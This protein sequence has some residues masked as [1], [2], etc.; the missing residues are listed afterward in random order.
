MADKITKQE[1]KE[2][3]K[4]QVMFA[5]AMQYLSRYKKEMTIAGG[6]VVLILV[7]AAGWY[8]YQQSEEGSA[9]AK[10]NKATEEYFRARATRTDPGAAAKLYEEVAK[11]YSGTRSGALASYRLGNIYLSLNNID[12]AIKAYQDFVKNS[13]GDNEFRVL[14]YNGIGYCYEAKKDFKTALENFE[15]AAGSKAGPSFAS[16]TYEN[17]ARVYESLNDTNK[18]VENYKKA[19]EKAVDPNTKE[20]LSRK[21]AM[22]G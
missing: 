5:E 3:D 15:K 2:P 7:V 20:L 17:I 22:L 12:G 21:I 8:F 11:N 6:V 4:L 9:L 13:S 18:A 10:F 14:A 1:L 16:I 19:L